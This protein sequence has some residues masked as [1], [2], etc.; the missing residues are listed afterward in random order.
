MAKDSCANHDHAWPCMVP[1]GCAHTRVLMKAH[2]RAHTKGAHG[3]PRMAHALHR[4]NA[5]VFHCADE[6]VG[7]L[8]RVV[9]HVLCKPK[10]GEADVAVLVQQHVLRL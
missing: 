2:G 4:M 10:V 9:L 6:A 7:T 8:V 1:R 3:R 5:H